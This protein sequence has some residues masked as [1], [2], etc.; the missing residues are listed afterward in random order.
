MSKKKRERP[1]D[2]GEAKERER[3]EKGREHRGVGFLMELFRGKRPTTKEM[4]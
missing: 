1:V 2:K 4:K 3:E